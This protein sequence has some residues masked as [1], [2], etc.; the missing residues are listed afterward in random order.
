VAIT[1]IPRVIKGSILGRRLQQNRRDTTSFYEILDVLVKD[2]LYTK[3]CS[4]RAVKY[5]RT[6][7][8][9][10]H[11]EEVRYTLDVANEGVYSL[12]EYDHCLPYSFASSP[13]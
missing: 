4:G 10:R 2:I 3:E 7:D 12:G 1:L 5:V 6:T 11:I 13:D 8:N 9:H